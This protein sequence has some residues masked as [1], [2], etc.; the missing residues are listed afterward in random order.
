VRLDG[1]FFLYVASFAYACLWVGVI[2]R[3]KRRVHIQWVLTGV[4]LDL[5]VVAGLEVSRQAVE[6]VVSGDMRLVLVIHVCASTMAILLY[7]CAMT[8]GAAYVLYGGSDA[9]AVWHRRAGRIAMAARTVG[10]VTILAATE[11]GWKASFLAAI[12]V[13][14]SMLA[15][16][17][18]RPRSPRAVWQLELIHGADPEERWR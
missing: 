2:A 14:M 18:F 10:F 7:V 5:L 1:D 9:F 11:A 16:K 15:W 6:T 8:L 12:P 13:A 4:S 3:R 17:R